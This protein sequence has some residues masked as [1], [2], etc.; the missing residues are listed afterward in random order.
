MVIEKKRKLQVI[1]QQIERCWG[2]VWVSAAE[3]T[4]HAEE[5]PTTIRWLGFLALGGGWDGVYWA[6]TQARVWDPV[7][8]R[9]SLC[10]PAGLPVSIFGTAFFFVLGVSFFA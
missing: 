10:A 7:A 1:L 9:S 8:S 3:S 6:S 5:T 4:V 2:M